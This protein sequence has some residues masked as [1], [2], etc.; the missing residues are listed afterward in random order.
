MKL[1]NYV[2]G[3][4]GGGTKTTTALANLGGK[5]LKT[6][7]TG[8]SSPRNVGP[9][10]AAKNLAKGIKQVLRK[11]KISSTFIGLAAI[12]EEPSLG[13]EIKK[14]LLKQKGISQ[15]FKGKFQ[16]E[17]DQITAFYS[18]TDKKDGIVLITGTGC[19]AH[20]WR[21]Q[22]EAKVSGWGIMADEG[23]AFW[24][25]QKAFQAVLK[26]LDKRGQKTLIT[27]LI[28]K[29]I[30]IKSTQEL[31]KKVYS[32]NLINIIPYFSILCD[33]ASIKGDK[34]AKQIMKDAAKELI[35]SAKTVIYA[36][37]FKKEEFPLVLV[38][39]MFKSKIILCMVEQEI[40]KIAPKAEI[41]KPKTEPVS[42]AIKLA[43]K[44]I[45]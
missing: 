30:K 40:K 2:I 32:E 43:L 27:N 16:I 45:Q 34:I 10:I 22:K 9:K 21:K 1:K 15:I 41:I 6:V 28:L 8:P 11:G 19:V 38:G 26:D 7:K 39:G 13:Q 29:E 24:V 37:G 35:L 42:G 12:E 5:I 4:D 36:L 3:I 25:G 14:E 44:S 20:G 23:S 31:L 18:G 33:E 17:S